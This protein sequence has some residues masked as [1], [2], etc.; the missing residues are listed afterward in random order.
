MKKLTITAQ[1]Y[2]EAVG[3]TM[4]EVGVEDIMDILILAKITGK[5]AEKLGFEDGDFEG[6]EF[7]KEEADEDT[8]VTKLH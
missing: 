1:E 2:V 4:D 8:N 6:M 7:N 5:I 3:T